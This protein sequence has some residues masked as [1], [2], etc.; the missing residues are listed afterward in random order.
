MDR[1]YFIKTLL[2]GIS[3]AATSPKAL[4]EF[5]KRNS[6][7]VQVQDGTVF[8]LYKDGVMLSE[9]TGSTIEIEHYI[10]EKVVRDIARKLDDRFM[11]GGQ[12]IHGVIGGPLGLLKNQENE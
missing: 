8:K 12:E 7:T 6:R 5:I 3:F 11:Y 9:E 10:Q 4:F 2:G 1:A